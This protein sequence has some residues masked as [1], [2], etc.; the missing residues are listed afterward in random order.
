MFLDCKRLNC[1]NCSLQFKYN[2]NKFI[3]KKENNYD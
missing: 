1:L 3:K 2:T